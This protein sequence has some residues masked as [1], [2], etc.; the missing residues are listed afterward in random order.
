ME[1]LLFHE[2]LDFIPGNCRFDF[3]DFPL[4]YRKHVREE[5]DDFA[6]LAVLTPVVCTKKFA[7]KN[8]MLININFFKQKSSYEIID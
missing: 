6:A 2:P 5:L 3:R 1:M 7:L 8:I 4:D